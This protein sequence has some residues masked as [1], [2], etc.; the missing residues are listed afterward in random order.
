MINIMNMIKNSFFLKNY[1]YHS[2]IYY[3]LII[4]YINDMKIFY[5]YIDK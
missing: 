1:F 4:K 2:I 5:L 3:C